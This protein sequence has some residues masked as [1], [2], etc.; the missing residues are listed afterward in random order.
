MSDLQIGLL[1]LGVLIVAGVV[2]FNWWQ[3]RQYRQR[4]EQGF[5]RPQADV[6]LEP[7]VEPAA[8]GVSEPWIGAADFDEETEDNRA[9]ST[10]A[11]ARP[12][13]TRPDPVVSRTGAGATPPAAV[14]TLASAPIDF[15][16]ELRA[17]EVIP[18]AAIGDL[19]AALRAIG[20]PVSVEGYEYHSKRWEALGGPDRW[21]T[22]LRLGLQLVDRNGAA[23]R[24]QIQK[25]ADTVRDHGTRMAAI[26]ELPDM[27]TAQQQA[28]DLDE[29]CADVDVIVGIN[30]IAQSGQ[31]FH[32]SQIRALGESQGLKLQPSGVFV[33][34][35]DGG[36]PL[37]TLD[38]QDSRAFRAEQ[39]RHLTTT[40]I[41][42]LLDVPRTA[43]GIK[44]FD[45][46]VGMSRQFAESLDGMLA[47]DNRALLNDVGLDKI[48]N[49][50][51]AIYAMM[52][53]RGIPAGS[54]AAQR[55]FS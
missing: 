48:R 40:G 44:V 43:D 4:S 6:L 36:K 41:T 1:L 20:R 5:A 33:Y 10:D 29:F 16:A 7:R 34:P 32:G 38:N 54:Q 39:M 23:S 49:Q 21:Y 53:H 51:R 18:G 35:G 31:V 11:P 26:A 14:E 27:A 15:V 2:A 22:S 28:L 9:E 12:V 3:E 45:R 42:F 50:L 30:V 25:F 17:G 24:E 13:E 46:M 37:F 55:L 47:D 19:E 52:E 8:A